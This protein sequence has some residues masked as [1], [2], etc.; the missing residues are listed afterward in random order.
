[1]EELEKYCESSVASLYY[2]LNEKT[3]DLFKKTDPYYRISL[4]HIAS[5]LGK[6]Q[7]ITNILRGVKHNA[8]YRRCYIPN[9]V[10]LKY[11]CTHEDFLRANPTKDVRDAVYE[12]ASQ[13]FIHLQ[14]FLKYL[15]RLDDE[16][17]EAKTLFLPY[18]AIELYLEKL[19]KCDF[20]IFDQKLFRKNGAL[21]LKIWWRSRTL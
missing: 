4:D 9:D 3:I 12:I 6:A 14:N 20:N 19:R 11:G 17:K 1:M 18:I 5:H 13:A 2:L 8:Q 21:P 10:L 15:K 7:G 16:N